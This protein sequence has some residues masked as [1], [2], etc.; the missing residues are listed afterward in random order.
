MRHYIYRK[1]FVLESGV[2][3]QTRVLVLHA[4][5]LRSLLHV[6]DCVLG[7]LLAGSKCHPGQSLFRSHHL[8]HHV[9]TNFGHQC[10]A[11]TCILHQSHRRVDRG[12]SLPSSL[13]KLVFRLSRQVI[14]IQSECW[15]GQ[16]WS[17]ETGAYWISVKMY[18]RQ[19]CSLT[20]L[21]CRQ[22]VYLRNK[23]VSSFL[24]ASNNRITSIFNYRFAN[25]LS[26]AH[27]SNSLS[28]TTLQGRTCN[29]TERVSV[30]SGLEGSGSSSMPI[31]S[32][33]RRV[34]GRPG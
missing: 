1:I 32:R 15:T 4:H 9:H 25:A 17:I 10:S 22:V 27:Y 21:A 11:A 28:L 3:F 18:P 6:G 33:C 19:R 34:P 14:K 30:T 23:I 20:V 31:C 12:K 24:S 8:A 5:H 16:K 2:D 13:E 7:E 26:F 29:V